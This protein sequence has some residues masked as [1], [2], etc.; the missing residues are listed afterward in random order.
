MSSNQQVDTDLVREL[1][2][3]FGKNQKTLAILVAKVQD[4]SVNNR[5]ILAQMKIK[6]LRRTILV[7]DVKS[8]DKK[9]E[10]ITNVLDE[11]CSPTQLQK[12]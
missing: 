9:I 3:E 10:I 7:E 8:Q 11:I 6:E 1:V 4:E 12:D 2:K 5:D